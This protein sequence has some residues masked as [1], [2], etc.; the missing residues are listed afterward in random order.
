[1]NVRIPVHTDNGDTLVQDESKQEEP[2]SDNSG[3]GEEDDSDDSSYKD[4]D[5]D[6]DEPSSD[7]DDDDDDDDSSFDSAIDAEAQRLMRV[8]HPPQAAEPPPSQQL[9]AYLSAWEQQ[10]HTDSMSSTSLKLPDS[11]VSWIRTDITNQE[12]RDS[13]TAGIFDRVI[14][15]LRQQ[16]YIQHVIIGR[17]WLQLLTPTQQEQFYAALFSQQHASFMTFIK[18]G[19]SDRENASSTEPPCPEIPTT[20]LVNQLVDR[21]WQMLTEVKLNGLCFDNA[22]QLDKCVQFIRNTPTLKLFNLLGMQLS[23]SLRETS[24]LFDALLYATAPMPQLDDVQL[25]CNRQDQQNSSTSASL[26]PAL[27]S[28][29]ALNSLFTNK[30]KQWRLTLDGLQLRDDHVHVIAQALRTNPDCRVND[31]LSLQDNP[32]ITAAGLKTLYTTCLN[33][34]RMGLVLSDDASWVATMD[35]VRPLN[36][37]HRRLEYKQQEVESNNGGGGGLV[38]VSKV[39]WIDW[40]VVLNNLPWIDDRRKLNYV[41]FTLLDQPDMVIME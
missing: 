27:V 12:E 15:G 41:W 33:K 4:E 23:V 21:S 18:L 28:A 6:S 34:Q 38:Y 3:G 40:L 10:P 7:E 26:R 17:E 29:A 19:G 20:V 5:D 14:T 36:N 25:S 37:L 39:R 11:L 31:L 22:Q 16:S 1:M 35:L 30:P 8:L 9:N 32:Q 2:F 24:N 13:T